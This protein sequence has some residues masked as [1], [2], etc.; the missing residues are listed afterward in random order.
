MRSC[1]VWSHLR[2]A[3][4]LIFRVHLT[5][6]LFLR[7]YKVTRVIRN[8]LHINTINR[9]LGRKFARCSRACDVVSGFKASRLR[10]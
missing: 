10:F 1:M 2:E 9:V 5:V 8:K 3:D 4:I 6:S 7:T